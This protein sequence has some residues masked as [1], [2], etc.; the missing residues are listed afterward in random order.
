MF[1]NNWINFDC[2]RLQFTDHCIWKSASKM[3]N[4]TWTSC[5]ATLSEIR[6]AYCKWCIL[7]N[8]MET[9]MP[10]KSISFV[11]IDR[12][13]G[14]NF[15]S[16]FNFTAWNRKGTL[17]SVDLIFYLLTMEQ[18]CFA[19]FFLPHIAF[20]VEKWAFPMPGLLESEVLWYPSFVSTRFVLG[21]Y[22][23]TAKNG[24]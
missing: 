22:H 1:N 11:L 14:Q 5:C 19:I 6:E 15:P 24:Q 3:D 13:S 10:I 2:K 9:W 20:V 8:F 4:S 17:P 21:L 23:L 16:D 7:N 18:L 12:I